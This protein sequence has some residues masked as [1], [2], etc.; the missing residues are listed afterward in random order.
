[1]SRLLPYPSKITIRSPLECVILSGMV[2]RHVGHGKAGREMPNESL[3]QMA[4]I[5]GINV[6]RE[7]H[8]IRSHNI[9]GELIAFGSRLKESLPLI[10]LGAMRVVIGTAVLDA[11]PGVDSTGLICWQ[12]DSSIKGG[13]KRLRRLSL[14]KDGQTFPPNCSVARHHPTLPE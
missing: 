1:M 10:L 13:K 4:S 3:D 7:R 6:A 8:L 12:S 2:R 5:I 9:E 11:F 14:K